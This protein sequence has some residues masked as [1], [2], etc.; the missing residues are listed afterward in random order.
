MQVDPQTQ[1]DLAQMLP[2]TV[3]RVAESGIRTPSDIAR[4]VDAGYTAF[5][6]G[7]SLMREPDPAAALAAL[8]ERQYVPER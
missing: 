2:S 8:L 3:V 5:L 1:I 7:E 4:M 6:I